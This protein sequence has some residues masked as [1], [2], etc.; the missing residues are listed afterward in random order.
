MPLDESRTPSRSQSSHSSSQSS[1]SPVSE[2]L[3]HLFKGMSIDQIIANNDKSLKG[4]LKATDEMKKVLE[5]NVKSFM[6][7]FKSKSSMTPAEGMVMDLE[8]KMLS[9]DIAVLGEVR[10]KLAG[11]IFDV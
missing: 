8:Y 4:Y 9:E 7:T 10:R 5:A 2:M 6:T 1:Y 3:K 11:A